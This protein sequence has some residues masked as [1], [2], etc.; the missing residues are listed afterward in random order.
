MNPSMK[1][2]K[3]K[4]YQNHGISSYSE[5]KSSGHVRSG[6]MV[7]GLE[8]GVNFYQGNTRN[9]GTSISPKILGRMGS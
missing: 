9:L 5:T 7:G 3:G 1:N 4:L 2:R 8:M 6:L